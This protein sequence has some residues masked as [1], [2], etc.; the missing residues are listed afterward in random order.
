MGAYSTRPTTPVTRI[1]TSH[2]SHNNSAIVQL[3][4]DTILKGALES[5]TPTRSPI[6]P[7]K[8]PLERTPSANSSLRRASNALAETTA[9]SASAGSFR[10]LANAGVGVGVSNKNDGRDSP[11]LRRQSSEKNVLSRRITPRNRTSAEDSNNTHSNSDYL[12]MDG[13]GVET[14][15]PSNST[16]SSPR[17]LH[18]GKSPVGVG[19]SSNPQYS[20]KGAFQVT[21]NTI[22]SMDDL[23][24]M[25]SASAETHGST[26]AA[27]GKS[28]SGYSQ[29]P[30][31]EG[32]L[33]AGAHE[34]SKQPRFSQREPMREDSNT[35]TR[36]QAGGGNNR[37]SRQAPDPNSGRSRD[38]SPAISTS[39]PGSRAASRAASPLDT[40]RSEQSILS[41]GDD[42]SPGLN[43]FGNT[44]KKSMPLSSPNA[45]RI[46]VDSVTALIQRHISAAANSI[47]EPPVS[48]SVPGRGPR[49]SVSGA[50]EAAA[51]SKAIGS[52]AMSKSAPGILPPTPSSQ[53][54]RQTDLLYELDALD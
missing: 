26:P 7:N 8:S 4:I 35:S 41:N 1:P 14:H 3:S 24:A 10:G 39:R 42:H 20:T 40:A 47:K 15:S 28:N 48:V 32:G 2:A 5:T 27:S 16:T 36:S 45:D 46:E 6:L 23:Q 54:P 49:V 44:F 18:N 37:S 12:M 34:S 53:P 31:Q 30:R 38:G 21:L 43:E 19:G 52:I 13:T 51:V 22:A 25:V 33:P 29:R 11:T 9:S 50:I 17:N